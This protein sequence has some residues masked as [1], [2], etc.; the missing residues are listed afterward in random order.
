MKK[1]QDKFFLYY[2]R[3]KYIHIKKLLFLCVVIIGFFLLRFFGIHIF[4]SNYFDLI[5]IILTLF[6]GAYLV[7][8]PPLPKNIILFLEC[9]EIK[10]ETGCDWDAILEET[11]LE[12][13][14]AIKIRNFLKELDVIKETHHIKDNKKTAYYILWNYYKRSL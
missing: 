11:N 2:N 4:Q 10:G 7:R 6:S 8:R 9:I 14:E 3:I 5:G 13:Q 1:I 12:I